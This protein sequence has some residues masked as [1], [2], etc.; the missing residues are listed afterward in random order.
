MS[1]LKTISLLKFFC[2]AEELEDVIVAS[3]GPSTFP[4]EFVIDKNHYWLLLGYGLD[5]LF[6]V[7][8]HLKVFVLF[9]LLWSD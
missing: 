1:F 3:S 9:L 5:F 2:E 8:S 6:F 7:L 4:Q